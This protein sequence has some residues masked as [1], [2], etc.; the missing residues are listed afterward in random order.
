MNRSQM[1]ARVGSKDTKPELVVR[2]GLHRKGYRF[3]LH[4][5][6]LPGTPDLVL[7]KFDTAI[8]VHGCF[9]HAH[10]GCRYFTLPKTRTHFWHAKLKRNS[11]RDSNAMALLISVGWR[12]LTVWECATRGIDSEVLCSKISNWLHGDLVSGE[13]SENG[14]T[15]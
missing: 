3:R 2:K 6:N 1:M 10:L 8:F 12:V 9:W 13:I 4:K 14:I 11:E 15:T 7:P 5:K